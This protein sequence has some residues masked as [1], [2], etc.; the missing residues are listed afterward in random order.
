M[1]LS[2]LCLIYAEAHL[3]AVAAVCVVLECLSGGATPSRADASRAH[4]TGC[5]TDSEDA[6]MSKLRHRAQGAQNTGKH[7]D[8]AKTPLCSETRRLR[9]GEEGVIARGPPSFDLAFVI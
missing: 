1:P 6:C 8:A 9:R 7:H 5:R 2:A 3:I 4:G